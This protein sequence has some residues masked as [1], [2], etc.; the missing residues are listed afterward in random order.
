MQPPQET[1][2]S[3]INRASEITWWNRYLT[4]LNR[5]SEFENAEEF[6]RHLLVETKGPYVELVD[7]PAPADDPAT[8][9]LSE[10]DYA[11]EVIEALVTELFGGNRDGHLYQHQ[12]EMIAAT[13]WDTN[14]NIITVPTAT[15]KTEAFLL[16]ILNDCLQV[17]KEGTKALI[18]YPMK[19]LAVDQLN[20]ILRYLDLINRSKDT[21]DRITVGIWD[22]DTPNQ[23]G[24]RE[25]DIEPGSYVRGLECPRTERKLTI[26]DEGIV[27]AEGRVYPW[28]KVTRDRVKEG[29]DILL[30]N[31]EAMDYAF[32]ND[33]VNTRGVFGNEIGDHPVKHIVF[34]EAHVWRG[35]KG[36]AIR[37][38]V[39][40]LRHFYAPSDPQISLV[41][42]T[43]KNPASL[44][45]GLTGQ[46]EKDI[47][48]ISFTGREL[49]VS[50]SSDFD[51]FAPAT[52]EQILDTLGRIRV[53]ESEVTYSSFVSQY[54]DLTD[55]LTTCQEVGLITETDAG[56]LQLAPAHEYLEPTIDSAV[57]SVREQTAYD[58]PREVIAN[59]DG[60]R[61]F[62]EAIL[63]AAGT[64]S[65]W[66]EF[67]LIHV[68]EVGAIDEWFDSGTMGNV[69]FKHYDELIDQLEPQVSGDPEEYLPTILGFGRLA[70][71]VTEKY[72]SFLK[73]PL[74]AYWCRGC[75]RLSRRDVC[76]ECGEPIEE[77]R[78]CETCHHPFVME[79]R[80]ATDGQQ[81]DEDSELVPVA[82]RGAG[83]HERCP[84][85]DQKV[86]VSDIEVP[87]TTLLSFMLTEMCR[88]TPSEKV[89]VFSDSHSSA[90]NVAKQIQ[91]T[92][93]GLM[94]ATLYIEYLLKN[95]GTGKLRTVY[96]YVVKQL[97]K[98]YWEPFYDSSL[99]PTGSAYNMIE[100]L[101]D[102]VVKKADLY[103]CD[104]LFDSALV[105]SNVLYEYVDNTFELAVGQALWEVFAASSS[106]SFTES[107]VTIPAL[108]R[109]KIQNKVRN[110]FPHCKRDITP[111]V[112][113]LL[114]KF[115]EEGIV[116][117]ESYESLQFEVEDRAD[118]EENARAAMDYINRQREEVSQVSEFPGE[119][120]LD[121]GLF[122][123][124]HRQDHS[125]LRLLSHVAYC[126]NCYSAY[127]ALEDESPSETCFKC[128]KSLE[129]YERF[130]VADGHDYSGP[131]FAEVDEPAPWALDHW[132]HDIMR[133][134]Q[135]GEADFVTVGIHKGNIPATVRGIIE[136]GFRKD[137]PEINIVSS[138]PTMELGVDIGTLDT[139]A[140]VGM[141][142]T[143]TNYVQRSGRTGRSRG[144]SSLIVTT[145]RG[146]HPVDNHFYQDLSRFFSEFQPVRVPPA[147]DF[148]QLLA[149][150]VVTE[151]MGHMARNP[152]RSNVFERS[153]TVVDN[154]LSIDEFVAKIRGQLGQ[155]QTVITGDRENALREHLREIFGDAGIR[156]FNEVFTGGGTVSLTHRFEETFEP[157][158]TA[159][160]DAV[161]TEDLT[162]NS[163]RL[164]NWLSQLGYLANY[165]T[166][167]H[168]FPVSFTG[169]ESS[170]SFEST[171]RLY[172][173]FPG[174]ENGRGAV[175]PMGG[176]DY[177]VDDVQAG[178]ELTSLGVCTNDECEWPFQG[179]PADLDGCPHCGEALSETAIH[180]VGS[181]HCRPA[182]K[183]EQYWNT[184]G[185]HT[186]HVELTPTPETE[187]YET[188]LFGVPAEV[189]NGAFEVTEFVYAFER[190]H[191]SSSGV[192]I[193]RS[194]ATVGGRDEAYA[195]V[196]RQFQATGIKFEFA[197]QNIADRLGFTVDDVPWAILMVS[198]E[199]ALQRAIAVTVKVELDDFQ[200][201]S[202]VDDGSLTVTV[203]DGR[204]GGNGVS[205]EVAETLES[206]VLP[207]FEDV[208]GCTNCHQYCEECL[209]LPRTPAFYLDNNLLDKR[210]LQEFVM[211]DQTPQS[212]DEQ[213]IS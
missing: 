62:E 147:Y 142:P 49:D 64:D 200:V 116:H 204:S 209:L 90:E 20:R 100:Q 43:V 37:L 197:K 165:R 212:T 109:E 76:G 158:R 129:V 157:L 176:R 73:P 203:V 138:T 98:E 58:Q 155:L 59:R 46:D 213:G 139:V 183:G 80:A 4:K 124:N 141:P 154:D 44:A 29:A 9:F 177:L 152:H 148:D 144:S 163:G 150:H 195:P 91:Q 74:K 88:V 166:F 160:R 143:L 94:A 28:V 104:F 120:D 127:P 79:E 69:E 151:V 51:R 113:A 199:Q 206:E 128:G 175:F 114:A 78:F 167:G 161:S 210:L 193:R 153:Y 70:G 132:A 146:R 164:D 48:V 24:D 118:R 13:E 186:T 36:A 53:S 121:S 34:D 35:I 205:W 55:A 122:T 30:T 40:R 196:G 7:P 96:H 87:T 75:N 61:L 133:P 66:H 97:R 10:F 126:S 159:S 3:A 50:S 92:E 56:T 185:L 107:K 84:D 1:F 171:G 179:Y 145:I 11:E 162:K 47:N 15:G 106:V 17:D 6:L 41:S 189:T 156:V 169:Y 180:E 85:C 12:A 103:N 112:D 77:L 93:Y 81:D 18:I 32:V 63:D 140:Q 172:D 173:M 123:R 135:D 31:P 117:E 33:S 65:P 201:K 194:E 130:T 207:A 60:R 190:R 111:L 181:V 82:L 19:T 86:S 83:V 168:Q 198:L 149:G 67:V 39:D 191:G 101:Q 134:L 131:G 184:R 202:S 71:V 105:T 14:S 72:H 54:P 25:R 8:T 42:A 102:D 178:R 26:N 45:H 110:K 16:P 5:M 68:P 182:Y 99:S 136:E 108:S 192:D 170:I 23:V 211:T 95:G 22:G 188:S 208:V 137:D 187:E 38:L 174:Q 57:E 52:L 125:Q 89:L 119:E 2:D 21:E 27:E 115:Y